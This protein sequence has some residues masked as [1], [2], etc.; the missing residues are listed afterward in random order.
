MNKLKNVIHKI[1]NYFI[2][3]Q[4]DAIC[5]QGEYQ[6]KIT[7]LCDEVN[8]TK[9]TK[10]LPKLIATAGAT[11]LATMSTSM[12][13]FAAGADTSSIDKFVDFACEWLKKI[14][15]VIMLVGGVMFALGWQ[16]ED[17]EGKTR[18]LQTL[19]AGAMVMALGASKDIFGL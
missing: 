4:T 1:K 6:N 16:R 15:A 10:K 14:G 11:M 17:A 18:G 3:K 13:V 9:F 8:N 5:K 19:M 12:T 2:K 7:S